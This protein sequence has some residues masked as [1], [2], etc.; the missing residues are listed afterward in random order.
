MGGV[1]RRSVRVDA[2][3]EEED[4]VGRG[5]EGLT[6]CGGRCAGVRNVSNVM[7]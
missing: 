1:R 5:C 2:G 7:V 4:S 6:E 3:S